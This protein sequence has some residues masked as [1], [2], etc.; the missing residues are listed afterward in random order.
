MAVLA[1]GGDNRNDA[2]LLPELSDGAQN[3][4][5]SDFAAQGMLESRDSGVA[6]L[7]ELVSLYSQRRNLAGAGKLRAATPVAV[8][9]ERIHVWQNPCRYNEIGVL[10]RLSQQV[11]THCHA[12]CLQAYQQLLGKRNMFGI[13]GR[14]PMTRYGLNK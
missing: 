7:E 14:I 4:G 12:V 1:G 5:F 6:R 13:G 2:K 8:A 3:S 9:P 10:A 11:Q